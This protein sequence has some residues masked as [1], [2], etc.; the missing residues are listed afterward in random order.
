MKRKIRTAISEFERETCLQFRSPTGRD[1]IQFRADD[2]GCYSSSVGKKGGK[3]KINLRRVSGCQT[4]GIIVHEIGH[5]IGLWHEQSRPDRDWFLNIHWENIMA[6]QN[7]QFEKRYNVD[8]QGESYDYQSVMHYGEYIFSKNGRKTISPKKSHGSINSHHVR[9]SQ[10]DIRQINR[11][12]RCPQA[13]PGYTGILK[14]RMVLAKDLPDTDGWW[15]CPDPYACVEAVERSNNRHRLCTRR[16][17]GTRYPR[18]NQELNFGTSS[19]GWLYFTITVW[20]Q[21]S[22][23]DDRLARTQTVYVRPGKHYESICTSLTR[24]VEFETTM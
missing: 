16:I 22:G 13:S 1:Y 19:S 20:D 15:N 5:A 11:M 18:W 14:V 4:H 23:R 6:G 9:L 8:Y 12:Y 3:Q 17:G 21:D 24:C 10:S 2:V 7:R